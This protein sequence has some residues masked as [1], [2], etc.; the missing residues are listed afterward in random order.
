LTH[1]T[2][3]NTWKLIIPQAL[4]IDGRFDVT[5]VI[6]ATDGN[7]TSDSSAGELHIAA[8]KVATY[9]NSAT[10]TITGRAL[11][12]EN[13][14]LTLNVNSVDYI[15]GDGNLTHDLTTDTWTLV[16]PDENTLSNLTYDVTATVSNSLTGQSISDHTSG[17]LIITGTPDGVEYV[18]IPDSNLRAELN[19][20]LNIVDTTAAITKT[21]LESLTRIEITSNKGISDASG[22]EYATGLTYLKIINNELTSLDVSHNTSLTH[23]YL[24]Y[25]ELTSLDIS[26]NTDLRE[27]Y[28]DNNQL[29]SFDTSQ[30][31]ELRKLK[32]FDNALTSLDISTNTELLLLHIENNELTS[33]DVSHNTSL[34]GLKLQYNHLT[35]LS[36]LENWEQTTGANYLNY[37]HLDI[38]AELRT[39]I[40]RLT[41]QG[42]TFYEGTQVDALASVN[43]TYVINED[44]QLVVD[45]ASSVLV[46]DEDANHPLA[47]LS[48]SVN[49]D[50]SNGILD[51]SSDGSFT[52]TP[53]ENFNGVDS[54]TY[55]V[56]HSRGEQSI[57]TVNITVNAVNDAPS[58]TIGANQTIRQDAGPQ[59]ISTFATSILEGPIDE[60]SQSL[61]FVV[62]VG[63]DDLS[64]FDVL[65]QIDSD[66][67]LTY[68]M[69]VDYDGSLI[70]VSVKLVDGGS[71]DEANVNESAE[72]TFTIAQISVD[73]LS[74]SFTQPVITGTA[75]LVDGESLSVE[76]AGTTYTVDDGSLTHDTEANT[77]KLI[78]P[79]ALAIDGR[80]D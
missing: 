50:V 80:F 64:A 71:S 7:K 43:D 60:S 49:S 59:T 66:G 20:V 67:N 18:N 32:L 30:N 15:V 3:A 29:T 79:Q 24:A 78:I 28:I 4:A 12:G 1:D 48:V 33:L 58:F 38:S 6:T 46:N 37:N 56:I 63:D 2:E 35:V 17:E 76:V 51:L 31:T 16:I 36:G 11:L 54:F 39:Q 14:I 52:Y 62:S 72:Q 74:T 57:A 5:A 55:T 70:S 34:T 69:A 68:T 61:N 23:L 47:E 10:P 40:D 25:N 9:T 77:W 73:A 45:A 44:T 8:P 13:D 53:N 26:T 22:L 19:T 27:M 75:I 21:Q 41:A 65:P 42:V